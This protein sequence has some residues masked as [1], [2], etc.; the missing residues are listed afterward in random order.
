MSDSQNPRRDTPVADLASGVTVVS[1]LSADDDGTWPP[2]PTVTTNKVTGALADRIRRRL[3]ASS[4]AKVTITE[5]A[6]YGGYSEYTQDNSTEFTVTAGSKS[7]TFYPEQSDAQWSYAQHYGKSF[8]D[9]VFARFDTWLQ[10]AERPE[11]LA[12]EWF[13]W[14]PDYGTCRVSEHSIVHRVAPRSGRLGHVTLNPPTAPRA[15]GAWS[16]R[17]YR[18]ATDYGFVAMDRVI[19]LS[20]PADADPTNPAAAVAAV[21]DALMPGL[22]RF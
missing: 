12:A 3:G 1:V 13:T 2:P 5:E 4:R 10:A 14:D 20:L 6:H 8:A 22:H 21:T 15:N 11:E 17:T 18:P 7:A 19:A 16:L 9:S